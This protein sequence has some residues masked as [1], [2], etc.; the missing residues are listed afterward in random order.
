M[1][2]ELVK[3]SQQQQQQIPSKMY[4]YNSQ[5]ALTSFPTRGFNSLRQLNCS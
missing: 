3:Q 2:D 5:Q 4:S 1:G